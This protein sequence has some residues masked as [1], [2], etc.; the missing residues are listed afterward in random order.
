[1]FVQVDRAIPCRRLLVRFNRRGLSLLVGLRFWSNSWKGVMIPVLVKHI[2][3]WDN[4]LENQAWHIVQ[5]GNGK[6]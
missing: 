6:G 3:F 4:P 1:M 5:H 2:V